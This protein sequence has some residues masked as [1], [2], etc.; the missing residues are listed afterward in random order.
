MPGISAS[1]SAVLTISNWQ[2][3]NVSCNGGTNGSIRVVAGGGTPPYIFDWDN[4]A[5]SSGLNNLGRYH[6]FVLKGQCSNN[7]IPR[8]SVVMS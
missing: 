5:S 2:V 7:T 4:G 6:N 1:A 8:V 3:Q